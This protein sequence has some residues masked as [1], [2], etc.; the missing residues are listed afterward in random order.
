MGKY[1][2]SKMIY[3]ILTQTGLQKL[4]YVGHSMGCATFFIA[5][6]THPKLNNKIDV[7]MAMAPAVAAADGRSPLVNALAPFVKLLEVEAHTH[8]FQIKI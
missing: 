8:N 6:I 5:M 7:M 1:D 4:S 2:V 3:Y